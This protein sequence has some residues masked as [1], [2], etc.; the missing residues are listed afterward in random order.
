MDKKNRLILATAGL[1]LGGAAAVGATTAQAA[2]AKVTVV[3]SALSAPG[4]N[5]IARCPSGSKVVGGGYQGEGAFANGGTVYDMVEANTPTGDG[6]GWGARFHTGRVI[7]H[8]RCESGASITV[9]K[10]PLSEP[11][12]NAIARCPSGSNAIGGGYQGEGAFANGGTAYDMVE[13]NVPTGDASGWGA[14]FHTGRVLAH[15]LCTTP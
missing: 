2:D 7:A 8:A 3:K 11:G 6:T 12:E 4:E 10:S 1:V 9:A 15:A 14:R 13:A 5:A